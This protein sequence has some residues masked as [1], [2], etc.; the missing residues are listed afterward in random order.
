[1]SLFLENLKGITSRLKL[2]FTRDWEAKLVALVLAYL[3]WY[4]INDQISRGQRFFN[5]GYAAPGT[6]KA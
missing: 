4:V 3:L 6:L 5:D 2:W 1:M